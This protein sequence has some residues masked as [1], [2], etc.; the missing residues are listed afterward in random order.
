MANGKAKTNWRAIVENIKRVAVEADRLREPLNHLRQM[1]E[2]VL[3]A[4]SFGHFGEAEARQIR[5]NDAV[6]V[7]KRR[8]EVPIH[9]RRGRKAVQQKQ[10]GR[11]GS[12]GFTV[13]EF[14]AIDVNRAIA[15]DDN[16][17]G[18]RRRNGRVHWI[19]WA[20]HRDISL[21]KVAPTRI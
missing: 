21:S 15:R 3:K 7:R 18:R 1:L 14:Q 5:S 13:K 19:G 4:F 20:R 6:T 9:V 16:R 10:R 12:S 17:L 11:L 8:N 2:A